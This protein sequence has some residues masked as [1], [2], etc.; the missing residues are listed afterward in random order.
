MPLSARFLGSHRGS[1]DYDTALAVGEWR[2]SQH[3]SGRFGDAAECSDQVDL[4]DPL[5]SVEREVADVCSPDR[6][7]QS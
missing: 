4:N 5:E 7:R 2:Q 3:A 6:G 1:V